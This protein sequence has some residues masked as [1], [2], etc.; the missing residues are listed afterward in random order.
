[1][2]RTCQQVDMS[3]QE[4]ILSSIYFM[5]NDP[6]ILRDM[7]WIELQNSEVNIASSCT[8]SYLM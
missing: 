2:Q 8:N 1:M 6:S 5:E 4:V 3:V 7:P